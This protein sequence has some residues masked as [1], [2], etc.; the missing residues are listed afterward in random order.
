MENVKTNDQYASWDLSKKLDLL[1]RRQVDS[2][3][4]RSEIIE[5]IPFESFVNVKI[6][7]RGY[8]STVYTAQWKPILKRDVANDG[9]KRYDNLSITVSLKELHATRLSDDFLEEIEKAESILQKIEE[10]QNVNY[11]CG[12]SKNP[13][14]KNYVIVYNEHEYIENT[15]N[16]WYCDKVIS[17]ITKLRQLYQITRTLK[18]LHSNDL[19]YKNLHAGNI[20]LDVFHNIYFTDF[21]ITHPFYRDSSI[22]TTASS[23]TTVSPTHVYGVLPYLAPE[24]LHGE[25]FTFESDVYAFGIIMWQILHQEKPLRYRAHDQNLAKDICLGLRPKII[26]SLPRTL[27]NLII[28]CWD[29]DP[30][31]RPTST[32]LFDDHFEVIF[33][34][35]VKLDN[36]LCNY[37]LDH[38]ELDDGLEMFNKHLYKRLPYLLQLK[39][40]P[41]AC[42]TCKMYSFDDLPDPVNSSKT[43]HLVDREEDLEE[44]KIKLNKL[45]GVDKIS[46]TNDINNNKILTR[47]QAK[48]KE[49][50]LQKIQKQKEKH[51]NKRRKYIQEIS[52]REGDPYL[53]QIPPTYYCRINKDYPFLLGE[54]SIE[55]IT[56]LIEEERLIFRSDRQKKTGIL[57][58]IRK[59]KFKVD[60][61]YYHPYGHKYRSDLSSTDIEFLDMSEEGSTDED[62]ADYLKRIK[63]KKKLLENQIL[64]NL[65][66][67]ET[68]E[69][70]PD[71]IGSD[72]FLEET[73][74][75]DDDNDFFVDEDDDFVV[76]D[77]P[78]KK[79]PTRR[80][81]RKISIDNEYNDSDYSDEYDDDE[82]VIKETLD[83]QNKDEIDEK[84][85]NLPEEFKD[86]DILVNNAGLAIG[87][88]PIE[89]NS[90]KD[91]ETVIDTNINGLLYMTQ[92][93][94][95]IMKRRNSGDIIN[96]GS[97][98]GT[99]SHGYGNTVYAATK[100]AT[101]GIT[102]SIRKETLSS[103]IRVTLIRPGAV[104]TEFSLVRTRGNNEFSKTYYDG[105]DP[106]SS[107]DIAECIVYTATRPKNVVISVLE[108]LPNAQADITTIHRSNSSNFISSLG[109]RY[110]NYK[111][112]ES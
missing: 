87:F 12:F 95:P 29:A 42:Y 94:L 74:V 80:V 15:L 86:I 66:D 58:E 41:K 109:D 88:D 60:Q 36:D 8:Y 30:K 85:A 26:S 98:S 61:K 103:K 67:I 19:V 46:E 90:Q 7:A 28:R 13:V 23:S 54:E 32:E 111:N 92:A 39:A 11:I 33:K 73:F 96:I 34:N 82:F 102:D 84:I 22:T 107:K 16:V 5:W 72:D 100:Y 78:R 69:E 47:R 38:E 55:P 2:A 53:R 70:E 108:V 44:L 45:E 1:G 52:N 56:D 75:V 57:D 6:Q 31:K 25:P 71:D 62:E 51:E 77:Q 63:E 65:K 89:K 14:T 101:E 83:I 10:V 20:L 17:P 21:G 97:I 24:I 93:V 81:K 91:I 35:Y 76:R 9:W 50:E 49:K 48:S 112:D 104:K 99:N 110:K 3:R 106:L 37:L 64:Q 4:D 40:D 27:I 68:D 43:E 105:F 18:S 79:A 59:R